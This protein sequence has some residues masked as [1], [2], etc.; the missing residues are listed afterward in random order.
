MTSAPGRPKPGTLRLVYVD[1]RGHAVSKYIE[2]SAFVWRRYRE[3][4]KDHQYC[5]IFRSGTERP[6]AQFT[7]GYNYNER[8]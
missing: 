4:Q 2:D 5:A 3:L 6:I 1:T 7:E 8:D